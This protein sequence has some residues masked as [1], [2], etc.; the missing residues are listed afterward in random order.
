MSSITGG[1]AGP[2]GG[3]LAGNFPAPHVIGLNGKPL[4]LITPSTSDVIR[5]TSAGG[6]GIAPATD[7]NVKD[8]GAYGDG[9]HDDTGAVNAALLAWF[10]AGGGTV[11][12]PTGHYL[13]L[14]EVTIPYSG[15]S[16][17]PVQPPL[18]MIGTSGPSWS[19]YWGDPLNG[20]SILDLRYAGG[21]SNV[22][23]L[24]TRGAGSLEIAH[25]TLLSGG[26]D[27]Y[28]IMQ[29]TNTSVK[30]HDCAI[31]GNQANSG[32]ACLQDFILLGGN[33][34]TVGDGPDD[35]F[36]GYGSAFH[37]NF[38][39]NIRQGITWGT[40]ANA[41]RV[42][43][44]A[45]SATC[46]SGLPEGAPYVFSPLAGTGASGNV[47]RDSLIECGAYPYLVA[48]MNDSE[49]NVFDGIGGYDETAVTLGGIYFGSS[50]TSYNTII[51]GIFGDGS[52]PWAAGPNADAQFL[53]TGNVTQH[54]LFPNGAY[55]PQPIFADNLTGYSGPLIG[56][57]NA[58]KLEGNGTF[59]SG[60]GAPAIAGALG[61]LYFRVDTPGTALQRIYICTTAGAA[62]AA[63]WTGIV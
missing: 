56:M 17:A 25:M 12:F 7:F 30:V 10:N 63:V 2:A 50:N 13:C 4:S 31:V 6:W 49:A 23:K 51:A 24:D 27:N 36:Q 21:G 37:N 14:G 9:V 58:F 61:D 47:L 53:L 45:Y 34:T 26:A 39:S 11:T 32:T 8:F 3:D 38:Y 44:E 15:P 55:F 29:T 1:A 46:G 28:R 54:P 20:G 41:I 35:A 16:A 19:G 33:S 18:R 59:N 52:K 40:Y 60:S 42:S 5:Y 57:T 43:G 62:G 48:V 22:A